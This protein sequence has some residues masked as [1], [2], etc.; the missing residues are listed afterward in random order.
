[1]ASSAR[2]LGAREI[3]WRRLASQHLITPLPA[4]LDVV[5]SLGV[6][7][8]QDYIGGK[9]G[10]GQR[11]IAATDSDIERELTDGTIVRTHVLLPTWHFVAAEDIRW[12][13]ELKVTW[14]LAV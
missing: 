2:T 13:R 8:S 7:Q 3:A 4:P 9:W 12:M 5:R 6:G 1:M 14:H 10:I 11:T